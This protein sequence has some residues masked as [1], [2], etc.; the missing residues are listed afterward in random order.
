MPAAR[1]PSTAEPLPLTRAVAAASRCALARLAHAQRTPV[2][3]ALAYRCLTAGVRHVPAL[4]TSL[5]IL[6]EPV[7]NPVWTWAVHAERPGA[8]ALAGGALVLVSSGVKTWLEAPR[9]PARPT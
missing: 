3:I 6:V 5:L 9:R 7:L 2:Q 4:E 1:L 8:W